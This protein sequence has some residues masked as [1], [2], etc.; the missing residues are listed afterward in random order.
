MAVS[1]PRTLKTAG[2]KLWRDVTGKYQLR[3][4]ELRTLESACRAQDLVVEIER[5]WNDIGRPKMSTGSM[6]QQVE[7]PMFAMLI[8]AQ[9]AFE[10]YAKRLNLPDADDVSKPNQQ[11]EAAQTRWAAAHGRSA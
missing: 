6:G 4:D 5:D 8:K 2:K 10:A 11:R 7:H 1:A 3:V 9:N